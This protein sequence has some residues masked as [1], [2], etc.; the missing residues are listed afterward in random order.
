MK[1]LRLFVWALPFLLILHSCGSAKK[2]P[3]TGD[4]GGTTRQTDVQTLKYIARYKQ[5][6]QREMQQYGIPASITMAQGILES[7]SGTSYLARTANNHFGIKCGDDWEGPRVYKDDDHKN[8]C[9]RKYKDPEESFRDHSEFLATRK[10]YAFLFRFSPSDY[11]AWAKGL[12]KAGYATDPSYPSKLI[13]LIEKYNLHE[14]DKEVL[15]RMKVKTKEPETK[16]R[17]D[18]GRKIIYE[19]KAGET[20][21]TIAKKFGIPVSEIK[22]MNNLVDYDIYEG[23]I[24][25]LLLPAGQA[26]PAE[27]ATETE[28]AVAETP[29]SEAPEVQIP[30][31][32]APQPSETA[33]TPQPAATPA[34]SEP[35]NYVLH[36]VQPKE[37]LYA[38]S[39]KYG[40][41]VEA[42]KAANALRDNTLTVGQTLKIPVRGNTTTSTADDGIPAYHI[43]QPG[44]TLYRIHVKYGIPLEKL[45][46]LNNLKD[47]TI[48]PGQ[49]LRLK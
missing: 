8:E 32:A 47:N 19:V 2:A 45:R 38:I 16:D 31:P 9:F 20:L 13:Y 21:Y 42:I 26:E 44:E 17:R 30:Q 34:P 1:R 12:K 18:D 23:Q 48:Y 41:S 35:E 5:I 22:E 40:V 10:R 28:E 36:T 37:T 27:S 46:E 49:K 43:V 6:A 25:V 3:K 4:T 7:A 14:L 15:A 33:E 11:E 24:L 39:R 29:Q